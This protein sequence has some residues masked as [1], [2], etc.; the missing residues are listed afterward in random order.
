LLSQKFVAAGFLFTD[1]ND[2]ARLVGRTV[3]ISSCIFIGKRDMKVIL[4]SLLICRHFLRLLALKDAIS[5]QRQRN[6][7]EFASSDLTTF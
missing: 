6:F 3:R 5:K 4:Y 1:T 2:E 7:D